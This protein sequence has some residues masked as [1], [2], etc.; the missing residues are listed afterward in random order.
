MEAAL[1]HAV[2]PPCHNL[3]QCSVG[4]IGSRSATWQGSKQPTVLCD[5]I[6]N[7]PC[8]HCCQTPSLFSAWCIIHQLLVSF[9]SQYQLY[10]NIP[11]LTGIE[12]FLLELW[13]IKSEI[14]KS[15]SHNVPM[16]TMCFTLWLHMWGPIRQS[17][18]TIKSVTMS[19]HCVSQ[20][21][22]S[23]CSPCALSVCGRKETTFSKNKSGGSCAKVWA[24]RAQ[25]QVETISTVSES[26]VL[27]TGFPWLHGNSHRHDQRFPQTTD[28]C[29]HLEL[30]GG[31]MGQLQLCIHCT[32]RACV[33]KNNCQRIQQ[34]FFLLNISWWDVS[35]I[36][37][38][39][40]KPNS[41]QQTDQKS[42]Q[43]NKI[44]T[45]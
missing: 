25:I 17:N 21:F 22:R 9:F 23:A 20:A 1:Q 34:G 39:G 12:D 32:A 42:I 30:P 37:W 35:K 6:T 3:A 24:P 29:Y 15:E 11:W 38:P 33:R 14:W 10:L 45:K 18:S 28:Q 31:R 36:M 41:S 26:I 16:W 8:L 27:Q 19:H 44:T 7:Q 2:M 43:S 13:C 4:F 5:F 40:N